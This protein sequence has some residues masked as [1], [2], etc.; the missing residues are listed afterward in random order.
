MLYRPDADLLDGRGFRDGSRGVD[1]G[2]SRGEFVAPDGPV[3]L[4]TLTVA[5][6]VALPLA[7]AGQPAAQASREARALGARVGLA[8]RLGR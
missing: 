7:P 4:P 5:A 1:L 2:S 6:N 3:L 8:Q